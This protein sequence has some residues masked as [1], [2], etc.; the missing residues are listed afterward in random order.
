MD[1]SCIG[2]FFELQLITPNDFEIEIGGT[3]CI[4]VNMDNCEECDRLAGEQ[5]TSNNNLIASYWNCNRW[6]L[7][8][9]ERL[10][11]TGLGGAESQVNWIATRFAPPPPGMRV[12]PTD[13][14]VHMFW[15]DRSEHAVDLEM[16][17]ID[18]ESYRIWRA[19]N[20][21]RPFGSS[22]ANG[23]EIDLWQLIDE[24]D[25][26]S[27]YITEVGNGNDAR[28]DTLALGQNTG[29]EGIAYRPVSLDAPHFQGLAAEMQLVVDSDS[30][31][32]YK[33]LP[34]LRDGVGQPVSG[35]E[36]LLP[37]ESYPAVLDTFFQVTARESDPIHGIVGKRPVKF[38]EYVDHDI[39]N[40]FLYF[41]SVT[42]T[43]H[44]IIF[45]QGQPR[46]VGSGLSGNPSSN[47]IH[48]VPGTRAQSPDEREHYG[49]NI[50]VYPNP[51]TNEALS[52]F[53]QLHPNSQDPSGKHVMFANLPQAHNKISIF[54][55]DGDLVQ[56]LWHDGIS[57]HGE[58]SWNLISRN[59]QEIL[60]GIYLYVV[61][62]DNDRFDDVIGKFVMIR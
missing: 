52:K 2:R 29:L 40:G 39:K 6:W 22:L 4:W 53:Q 1:L 3:A 37:W 20:W 38:Y 8:E 59:G 46:V 11:C 15:D 19:D 42:A 45:R 48:A 58:M 35:L 49:P 57:G 61:E 24:F 10:G 21:D 13:R 33:T 60:S 32:L 9:Q 23:P 62:S 28:F 34:P 14:A 43:D 51:V 31:G 26:E 30:L 27:Y 41:Y 56:E 55:L 12:W 18:F 5:C 47:F 7:P 17:L 25:S 16:G 54:T 44:R 36:G 50:Y